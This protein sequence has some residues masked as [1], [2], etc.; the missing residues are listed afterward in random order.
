MDDIALPITAQPNR[1]LFDPVQHRF[2]RTPPFDHLIDTFPGSVS[3]RWTVLMFVVLD[4]RPRLPTQ[5]ALRV[6]HIRPVQPP[7]DLFVGHPHHIPGLRIP[8]PA[9]GL[10]F[11]PLQIPCVDDRP[12]SD[13]RPGPTVQQ[14]LRVRHIRPCL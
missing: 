6:R 9:A 1:A 13:L 5:Q 10:R 7:L 8:T 12:R 2:T 11:H 3:P 4:I 14:A